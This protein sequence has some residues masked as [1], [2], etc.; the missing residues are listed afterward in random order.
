M[1]RFGASHA[2]GTSLLLATTTQCWQLFRRGWWRARWRIR[3]IHQRLIAHVVPSLKRYDAEGF[4]FVC[5]WKKIKKMR[6]VISKR[7]LASEP[8]P[9]KNPSKP[10]CN[11]RIKWESSIFWFFSSYNTWVDAISTWQRPFCFVLFSVSF[12]FYRI[13]FPKK[14]FWMNFKWEK[15]HNGFIIVAWDI[16][17]PTKKQ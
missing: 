8:K 1:V 9:K 12:F 13:G 2:V 5:A 4:F 14:S 10:T 15:S 16:C 17:P 7:L 6:E 11:I 3:Q